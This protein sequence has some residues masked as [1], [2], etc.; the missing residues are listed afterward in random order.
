MGWNTVERS[1]D[2]TLLRGIGDDERFYF[3]H[4]Y[5]ACVGAASNIEIAEVTGWSAHGSRFAAVVETGSVSAVQFHP[6]KSADA[7]A[8]LLRNWVGSL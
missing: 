3:V 5:A 7:G 1:G 6:E 4:S 8:R 2:S